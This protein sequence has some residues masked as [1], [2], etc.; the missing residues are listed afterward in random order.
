M[1]TYFYEYCFQSSNAVSLHGQLASLRSGISE[2]LLLLF[3]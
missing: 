3:L 2:L 1:L